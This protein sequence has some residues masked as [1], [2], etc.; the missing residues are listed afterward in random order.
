MAKLLFRQYLDLLAKYLRPQLVRVLILSLLIVSSI[1]LR[2]VNP[3]VIRYFI[4]TAKSGGATEKL[5]IAALIFLAVA[6]SRHAIDV[7]ATY[8]RV[9]SGWTATNAL[10]KDLFHH[11][12]HLDMSFHN[13]RTP[14]EMIERIDG[15]VAVLEEFFSQFIIRII[16]NGLLLAG[17]LILLFRENWQ[18]GLGLSLFTTLALLTVN[19]LRNIAVPHWKAAREVS[20]NYFGFL[21]DR[22]TGT[23]AIAS[24]KAKP[25]ILRGFADL[26]RN[27]YRKELKAWL[28]GMVMG[29]TTRV[30][31]AVGNALALGISAYLF[32]QESIT[33]GTVYLIFHYTNM[34]TFPMEEILFQ[35]EDLQ[36]AKASIERV[37]EL[38]NAKTKIKD[39]GKDDFSAGAFSVEF[40]NVSFKYTEDVT[41]LNNINFHLEPERTLGLL[42]R[43]GSGKTTISRLL[44]RLYEPFVGAVLLGG[45]DIQNTSLTNLRS[46][47]GM[48]TQNVQI[49]QASVR[50]NLTLFRTDIEDSTILA[51]LQ[52]L[53]LNKWLSSLE[54]GLETE[55][56]S[57]G[58]NLSAGEAQ[59]LAF[60]RI[61]LLKDPGLVILDEASSRLDPATEHLI[62]RAI[63]KLAL[64]HSM[65]VIAH[66]LATVHRADDIMILED[67]KI[68]EYSPRTDLMNDPESRFY[69]LLK[70][71][72]EELLV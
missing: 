17:I 65:I 14:G 29:N 9:K 45:K 63:E 42:G 33:I 36:R 66:R 3:Q 7:A 27:W 5:I 69:Q 23:E 46:R 57:G 26:T 37:S 31:F 28:M 41:V 50:D 21:E 6:L 40:R 34:L 18:V 62:N 70:T 71:G 60:A 43:T 56:A 44:F 32:Y 58:R 54:K 8:F 2:L 13:D 10:R 25:F 49:F 24:S 48:V 22:I 53:G 64:N 52:D 16:A 30:F 15:D 4:D 51:V 47:V 72:L 11:T 38:Q 55:L 20:A 19:S 35:M 39:V 67:G 61:F 12:L 68:C 1:G 59:L